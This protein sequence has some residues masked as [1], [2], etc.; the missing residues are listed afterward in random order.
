MSR[1][2]ILGAV[3][4]FVLALALYGIT[5][6]RDL[7]LVDSAELA[8]SC[9]TGSVPH[10]PGFP[11]Y[12]LLGRAA[13]AISP[14]TP[15]RTMNLLSAVCGAVSVAFVFLLVERMIA[16]ACASARRA[17]E[18]R[19][20]LLAAAAAAAAWATARNPWTWAGVT[21]VYALN[22]ALA[23]AAW[24]FGWAA[25]AQ[26]AERSGNGRGFAI[27]A[28]AAAALG[29]ANHHA[30]ALVVAPPLLVLALLGAPSIL[31][32]RWFWIA[33]V[34]SLGFTLALY[35]VLIVAGRTERGLDWGGIRDVPLL[36]RHVL[37][38]QYH[39]QFTHVPG[40][41]AFVAREFFGEL[42]RGPGIPTAIV[43]LAGLALALAALRRRAAFVAPLAFLVA[44]VAANLT[45]SL[46][47]V[48]GPEDRIAYDLPAH[49]AWCAAAG[50][51]AW[52]ILTRIRGAPAPAAAGAGLVL[53]IAGW[54]VVRNAGVCDFREEHVART[55]VHETLRDVPAGGVV[56]I[57]EWNFGAPY[58][59]M[60]EI[61]GFRRDVDVI[62]ILMMRRFW[63]LAT[64]ERIMPDLV[65]A[66]R[67]QFDAFRE[68]VTLFDL[69]RPYDQARIQT[70][71]ED[72]LRRWME[73]GIER[74]A[75]AWFDWGCATRPDEAS[76][77]RGVQSVPDEL[78]IR[79]LDPRPAAG[80]VAPS[81]PDHL[82]PF[83]PMDAANLRL[84]S[85]EDLG[86]QPAAGHARHDSTARAV[87]EGDGD[88]PPGA[89]SVDAGGF[90]ARRRLARGSDSRR[91]ARLVSERGCGVGRGAH[92]R[93]KVARGATHSRRGRS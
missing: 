91:G 45:L 92:P 70:L 30:T 65:A 13:C 82:L 89:G 83:S 48:V 35:L 59:Y 37:G 5:S 41:S 25:C 54:N 46:A 63:Y 85:L 20:R 28:A 77:V 24:A 3:V 49:L 40:E 14:A 27:A 60:R 64:L 72:L 4:S 88:V 56:L 33:A 57:A 61:E 29:L 74:G 7:M 67:P 75:G 39:V 79:V 26:V 80:T 6:A 81:A 66:S 31:R 8:L 34:A 58:F 18:P 55:F 50:L 2:A 22:A 76:W 10:P 51:G 69:G 9:A 87:L 93:R 11:L 12:F 71:Y 19:L 44:A 62:D 17:S 38:R 43:L 68:Q 32:A 47:Y 42:L 78:L 21:E 73:I 15:I 84:P 23:A 16:W 52:G 1:A 90:D 86:R 53:L 36:V